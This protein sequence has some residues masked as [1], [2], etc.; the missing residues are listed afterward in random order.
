VAAG[1]VSIRANLGG[2]E[3]CTNGVARRDGLVLTS[4][5]GLPRT[6]DLDV[7]TGGGVRHRDLAVVGRDEARDLA[8]LRLGSAEGTVLEA[9]DAEAG[10]YVW[11]LY[12]PGCGSPTTGLARLGTWPSGAS[13]P[14][15]LGTAVEGGAAGGPL[16]DPAGELLGIVVSATEVVPVSAAEDLL[17]R[18]LT[19]LAEGET[20]QVPG[21]GDGGGGFPTLWVVAGVAVV[22]GVAAALAGGGGGDGGGNG[23]G[24]EPSGI[25]ITLP[26]GVP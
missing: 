7:V 21:V 3:V 10:D 4:L 18:A 14:V 5:S 8:V 1:L 15:A 12:R 19:T 24:P 25:R 16:V 9:G 22:G 11:T 23:G 6:S 20:G 13:G 17:R 2:G 26:G